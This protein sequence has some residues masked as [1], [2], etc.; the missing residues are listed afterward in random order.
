MPGMSETLTE[1]IGPLPTWAWAGLL[2]IG[3]A[4][5]LVYRKKK[6]MSAQAAQQSNQANSSSNL[7]TVPVSNL[8]TEAQ[9]M[10]VQMGDVFVNVPPPNVTQSQTQ[11]NTQPP[12][13]NPSPAPTPPP[14]GNLPVPT[15]TPV[16]PRSGAPAPTPAPVQNKQT[17]TVCEWPNWCGSLWGIAAHFYGNG[18]NW[19]KIYQANKALIGSNPNRI[20]PGQV[21]VI[22]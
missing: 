21:L 8:T 19:P 2:T 6:A 20:H 3:V 15:P 9:P 4:A 14:S 12:A 18:A 11:T 17:V 22:P 7:G 1:D 16:P 13:P 10:P 5:Y